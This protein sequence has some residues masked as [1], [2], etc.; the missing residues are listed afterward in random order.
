MEL[1]P[2]VLVGIKKDAGERAL[3]GALIGVNQTHLAHL[4][5]LTYLTHLT[6]LTKVNPRLTSASGDPAS[7]EVLSL[8]TLRAARTCRPG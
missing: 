4:A 8:L 2:I 1:P 5:H 7:N 3:I 6:A